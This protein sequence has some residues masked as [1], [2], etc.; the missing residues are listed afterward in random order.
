[1]NVKTHVNNME[2][3][4]ALS[5]YVGESMKPYLLY[6]RCNHERRQLENESDLQN[7]KV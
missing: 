2:R 6:P 5:G 4:S 1:V 3:K 7:K